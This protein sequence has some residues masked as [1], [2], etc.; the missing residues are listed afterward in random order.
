MRR[1]V[2]ILMLL[3]LVAFAAFVWPSR[4]RYEHITIDKEDYLVRV[5]RLTGR[6]DILVPEQGWTPADM[7]WDEEPAEADTTVPT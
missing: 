4:W 2:S 3:A 1:V 7:P 5:E 6:A